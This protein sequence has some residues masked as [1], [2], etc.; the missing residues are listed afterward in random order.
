MQSSGFYK[1]HII[2]VAWYISAMLICMLI[3]YP[4]V[5]K[6]RKNYVIYYCSRNSIFSMGIYYKNIWKFH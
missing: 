1:T 6:Y 3:I 2:A 5:L 4:L